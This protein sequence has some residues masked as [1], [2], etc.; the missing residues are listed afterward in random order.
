MGECDILARSMNKK[1][2]KKILNG[3]AKK[4]DW[5]LTVDGGT[6]SVYF[7]DIGMIY[8]GG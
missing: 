5:K 4:G 2:D 3:D 1:E 7:G 8:Q 6:W